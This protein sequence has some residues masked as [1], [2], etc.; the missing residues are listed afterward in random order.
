MGTAA[1]KRNAAAV[2]SAM[3]FVRGLRDRA[4]LIARACEF[5]LR[6]LAAA[7]A[8]ADG[9]GAIGRATCNLVELH[10]AG[11]SV[12][13]TDHGHAELQQVGDD[14]KQRRLLTAM[15]GCRRAE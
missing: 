6:R 15:L 1:A 10:L 3:Q 8:A 12:I 7:V 5:V 11:K 9:G 2:A 4:S 14:R 13:Q